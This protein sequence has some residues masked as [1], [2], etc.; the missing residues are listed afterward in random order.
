M[1]K[2]AIITML[3]TVLHQWC[4]LS[5]PRFEKL[6]APSLGPFRTVIASGVFIAAWGVRNKTC[7]CGRYCLSVAA[8]AWPC[9]AFHHVSIK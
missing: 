8:N 3:K 4:A 1:G 7:I 9:N 5:P 2:L 6:L